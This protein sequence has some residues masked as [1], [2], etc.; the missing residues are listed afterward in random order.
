MFFMALYLKFIFGT[1]LKFIKKKEKLSMFLQNIDDI[2]YLVNYF[3]DFNEQ[4]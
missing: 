2:E 1:K 4:S 3:D